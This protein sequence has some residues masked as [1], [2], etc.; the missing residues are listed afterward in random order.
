[1]ILLAQLCSYSQDENG[2][3]V[4][5][6]S[7]GL[8]NVKQFPVYRIQLAIRLPVCTELQKN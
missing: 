1:M 8:I 4:M 3:R 7:S 6:W 5:T 2:F